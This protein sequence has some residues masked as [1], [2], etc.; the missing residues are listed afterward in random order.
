[1]DTATTLV[2]G[3]YANVEEFRNNQPSIA[4]YEIAKDKGAELALSTPDGNG[5][6]VYTHTAWGFCDGNQVFVMMDG[7]VFPV[8]RG[9]HQF[10]VLGS[11]EYRNNKIW[12]PFLV[13]LGPAAAVYGITDVHDNVVRSLRLFRLNV[14]SGRVTE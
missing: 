2:K 3:V 13:P 5:H 1:M 10:Y 8:V 11:R 14:R 6:F 9:H 4:Q 12:V 7:N